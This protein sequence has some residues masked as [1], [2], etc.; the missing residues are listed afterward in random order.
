MTP[1]YEDNHLLVLNKLAGL[2]TQPTQEESDSLEE[3][4]KGYLKE[5]WSKQGNV[6]LHAVHRLDK[7]V[8]GVVL[9]AKTSKALSRL[10][11]VMREKQAKKIY[12]AWVE[13]EGLS[14]E[15]ILRHFL[16]H[17]NYK[18]TLDVENGKETELSYRVLKRETGRTL[19]EIE[20]M[21][22]RYHQIRAQFSAIGHPILGDAK[23]GSRHTCKTG[24][25][26]LHSRSLSIPH[27]ITGELMT[28][29]AVPSW[30]NT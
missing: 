15:G 19:V 12:I 27:P 13:G 24:T 8:S 18:A 9:F 6:F 20:L 29:E 30:E 25:I 22:G 1:L 14:D 16:S 23:Y 7:A 11:A 3:R 21:T 28:F 26:L 5:K 2:L 17:G 4:A 10:N